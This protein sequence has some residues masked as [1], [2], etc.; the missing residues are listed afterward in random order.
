M[1]ATTAALPGHRQS[2]L[3]DTLIVPM[4]AASSSAAVWI[5]TVFLAAAELWVANCAPA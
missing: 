1:Q 3:L 2:R 4:F 5:A